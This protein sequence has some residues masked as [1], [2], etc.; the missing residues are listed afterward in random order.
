[1]KILLTVLALTMTACG[2]E[3]DPDQDLAAIETPTGELI[4]LQ[5]LPYLCVCQGLEGV[6]CSTSPEE[7]RREAGGCD[8]TCAQ[9]EDEGGICDV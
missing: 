1:M 6:V 8:C 5:A 9:I 7:A 2:M 4:Q 3:S